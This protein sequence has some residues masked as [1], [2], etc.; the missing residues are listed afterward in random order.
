MSNVIYDQGQS[1]WDDGT[2][3]SPTQTKFGDAD[4]IAN[5]NAGV[6]YADQL[7]FYEANPSQQG[8]G[9]IGGG[10]HQKLVAGAAAEKAAS[11]ASSSTSNNSWQAGTTGI[12][13]GR[14]NPGSVDFNPPETD[15]GGWS[16]EDFIRGL[17]K[18]RA[19]NYTD[20]VISNQEQSIDNNIKQ[21]VGNKGDWTT[22]IGDNNTISNASIGNDYSLNM[23]TINL[24]NNQKQNLF[25]V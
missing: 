23:G 8:G 9:G 6:S 15:L 3:S 16:N 24:A 20:G 19:E 1:P 13:A 12:G 4:I 5:N 21:N 22:N 25:A 11:S 17:A 10:V 14:Y 2:A 7:A 18:E